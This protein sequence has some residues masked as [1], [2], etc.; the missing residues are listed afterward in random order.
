MHV[1]GL[2]ALSTIKNTKSVCGRYLQ[3]GTGNLDA[4]PG[5]AGKQ[6]GVKG[7]K[8]LFNK[9][10]VNLWEGKKPRILCLDWFFSYLSGLGLYM[11]SSF[12]FASV[13]RGGGWE[14]RSF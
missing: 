7:R 8:F 13:Q 5:I 10:D 6:D 3:G 4:A 2:Y 14:V 9:C 11:W 12:G 1:F